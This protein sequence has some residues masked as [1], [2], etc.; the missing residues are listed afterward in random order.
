MIAVL[1]ASLVTI[2][3]VVVVVVKS[4]PT[5][6]SH[7]HTTSPHPIT[8]PN[9]H[10]TSPHHITTPHITTPHH[11]TQPPYHITTPH[12]HT[13]SPHHITTTHH[14]TTSP[15]PTTILHLRRVHCRRCLSA[16][17]L[18]KN[19]LAEA[20]E[21]RERTLGA[22]SVSKTLLPK[23]SLSRSMRRLQSATR[24]SPHSEPARYCAPSVTAPPHHTYTTRHHPTHPT[25]PFPVPLYPS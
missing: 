5:N 7:H 4:Y 22:A 1:A 11:Q 21:E 23:R 3:E 6:L 20:L 9:H 15:H 16:E 14:H 8:K 19:P 17:D 13:T 10:T 24:R 12:H 18:W 25:L 2:L